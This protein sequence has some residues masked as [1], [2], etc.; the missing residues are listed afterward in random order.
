MKANCNWY[1]F[2][3]SVIKGMLSTI[4]IIIILKQIPHFFGYDADWEGDLGFIES[5]GSNTF[6]RLIMTAKQISTGSTIIA[7]VSLALLI[8]WDKVLTHKGQIFRIV[9]GPIVAVAL[10]IVYSVS[11]AD[12]ALL[13]DFF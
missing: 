4:G 13:R 2:P 10:G 9:Q 3:A 11:F 5:D 12:D 1:F 8:L 6:S 7:V